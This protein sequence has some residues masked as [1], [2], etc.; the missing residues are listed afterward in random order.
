MHLQ[1]RNKFTKPPIT[2]NKLLINSSESFQCQA[3]PFISP[4][5]T[6]KSPIHTQKSPIH[7]QKS[8]I[9]TKKIPIT[10]PTVLGGCWVLGL[11]GHPGEFMLS[12]SWCSEV[13]EV[14]P[15]EG[16]EL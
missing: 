11:L 12:N 5:H 16:A 2:Y 7:T 14:A 3:R 10:T 9:H 15:G 4:I 8:P 13:I 6:Q 1:V